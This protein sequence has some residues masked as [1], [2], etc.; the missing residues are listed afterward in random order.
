MGRIGNTILAFLAILSSVTLNAQTKSNHEAEVHGTLLTGKYEAHVSG[1]NVLLVRMIGERADSSYRVS[2]GSGTFTFKGLTPGRVYIKVTKMG[3]NP[4]DGVFDLTEGDNAVLFTMSHSSEEIA[5]ASITGSV[6]LMRMLG[7]TTV[8]NASAVKT[9]SGE[10]A[11]AI[12]EQLPGFEV[13]GGTIR[14]RGRRVARTYVNGVQLFGDNAARTFSQL[15]A[16]EVTQI[17][18]YEETDAEDERRGLRNSRKDQV[19]DVRTKGKI[20]SVSS[21]TTQLAAGADGPSSKDAGTQGRYL[22]RASADFSS[23]MRSASAYVGADNL[24]SPV[25]GVTRGGHPSIVVG[26]FDPIRKYGENAG[27]HLWAER[28][29]KDRRYGNG[30]GVGYSLSHEY[31]RSAERAITEYMATDVS[32]ERT[33]ADSSSLSGRKT[34]HDFLVSG[35]LKDTPLKSLGLSLSGTFTDDDRSGITSS[36]LT[37]AS[38]R[39]MQNARTGSDGNDMKLNGS[40]TWRDNDL[41]RVR[42]VLTLSGAYS[43][44]ST[45][46]WNTDTLSS[47]Y[48]RRNLQ[49]DGLGSSW[50]GRAAGSLEIILRNTDKETSRMTFGAYAGNER[51]TRSNLTVDIID[52]ASPVNDLANTYDFTWN[53]VSCGLDQGFSLSRGRAH[54]KASLSET[55]SFQKDDERLPGDASFSHRYLGI[56]PSFRYDKGTRSV[57]ISGKPEIPSVEQS[58]DRITD[59]NPL[60]LTGGNPD[61]RQAY[62]ATLSYMD[63]IF[64]DKRTGLNMGCSIN[65]SCT[66]RPVVTRT[67]YF[68]EDTALDSYGGYTAK[69]GAML[70][71]FDNADDPACSVEGGLSLSRRSKKVKLSSSLGLTG[72]YESRPQYIR[73]GLAHVS[74]WHA[75]ASVSEMYRPST[76]FMMNVSANAT[77]LDASSDVSGPLTE[78]LIANAVASLRYDFASQLFLSAKGSVTVHHYLSGAGRDDTYAP[79]SLEVGRRF[80]KQGLVLTAGMYDILS[81]GSSYST[82]S[83]AD[84]YVQRWTPSYGRYCLLSM[85]YEFRK[86]R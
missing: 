79:V 85:V 20:L 23:E 56:S 26:N 60:V 71:T 28:H 14:Y 52:P 31:S 8:F 83:T 55:M 3:M 33:Y 68:T 2:T 59:T 40:L 46:S 72:G 24:T 37:S 9:M 49:S 77:Y 44:N 25:E 10:D 54:I 15:K 82:L 86:R 61:L 43:R 12:L 4:A 78:A 16:E 35:D 5:A 13:S 34:R 76:H 47:S 80:R 74:S 32:P 58:R 39:I 84:S 19:L 51:S 7:D 73:D 29:W 17:R 30:I 57:S 63:N 64:M 21:I 65:A 27:C 38:G 11:M 70:N 42:P 62:T 75:K 6:P 36:D 1:A 67:Y 18:A 69:A 66:F 41:G 81:R 48:V 50:N 22:A 53:T 45:L